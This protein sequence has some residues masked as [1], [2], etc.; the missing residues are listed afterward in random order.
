MDFMHVLV[1]IR[2]TAA[3]GRTAHNRNC[4]QHTRSHSTAV[5]LAKRSI[6]T[7][8]KHMAVFAVHKYV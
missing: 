5:E 1:A 3:I 8:S 2:E 6:S 4:V 7:W